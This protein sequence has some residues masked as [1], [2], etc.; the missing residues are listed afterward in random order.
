[1]VW[2]KIK[3]TDTTKNSDRIFIV[4]DVILRIFSFLL[5]RNFFSVHRNE[6]VLKF[7]FC[8]QFERFI[9]LF[10]LVFVFRLIFVES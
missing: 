9:N 2:E 8:N 7:P 6:A 5:I 4:S 10:C 1:M 3:K